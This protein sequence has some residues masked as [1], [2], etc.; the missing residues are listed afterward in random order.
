M[1]TQQ[2]IPA[3]TEAHS[4]SL[5]LQLFDAAFNTPRDPRSPEYRAGVMHIL[6]VKTG[7]IEPLACPYPLGT[8]RA[9]AWFS[10][11]DEGHKILRKYRDQQ[12]AES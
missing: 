6:R 10:G 11:T 3:A 1:D 5:A 9:D 4:T 12:D 2:A 7:E 8:A